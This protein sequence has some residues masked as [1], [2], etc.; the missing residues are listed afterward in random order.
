MRIVVLDGYTLSQGKPV[1]GSIAAQGELTVH[2]RTPREQ[3]LERARDAEVLLTNKTPLRQDAL[4]QLPRLKYIAVMATGYNV[5][6][7]GAARSRGIPVSNVPEYG[8]DSVAQLTIALLLELCHRVGDH[9][10]AVKAGEWTNA[11]DWCFWKHPLIELSGLKMGIV[12][13]GRI[14]RK[15]GEIARALGMEI[16]TASRSQKDSIPRIFAEA[17]V[18]SLHCPETPETKGFVT[19]ELLRRMK[20]SAFLLNTSRGSLI[21][22]KSLAAA[23]N[24]GVLAGAALDVVSQEPIRSDNPLL[25]ARNCILT[26]HLAWATEAARGRLIAETAGNLAAFREGKP[27]NVVN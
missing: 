23:L 10:R 8:T 3:L 21:D 6:D 5:V 1:W 26:P 14:G 19:A 9:D 18:V 17:D 16:L 2:D 11:A 22:E 15:V 13:Y 12:G 4:E 25:H 24:D 27:R 7:A 20:K